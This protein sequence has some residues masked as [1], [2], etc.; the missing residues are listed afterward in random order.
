MDSEDKVIMKCYT[1]F[2][3]GIASTDVLLHRGLKATTSGW[4]FNRGGLM[5]CMLYTHTYISANTLSFLLNLARKI[6]KMEKSIV[7][8]LD[9][10][11]KMDHS[12][13]SGAI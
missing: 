7:E 4:S 9:H 11:K 3:L 12:P 6:E 1:H 13:T 8:I 5:S 2:N 10:L